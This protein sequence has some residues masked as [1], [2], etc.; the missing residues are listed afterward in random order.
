MIRKTLLLSTLLCA[1]FLLSQHANAG[2]GFDR[3]KAAGQGLST[4]KADPNG[5]GGATGESAGGASQ[6]EAAQHDDL[7]FLGVYETYVPTRRINA[8]ISIFAEP[9][10]FKF[11]HRACT[12][13]LKIRDKINTYLFQHPPTMDKRSNVETKGM[14][15]GI[16]QAIKDGLRTKLEYF[17]SI[18]VFSGEWNTYKAPTEIKELGMTDCA[19]MIERKAEMDKTK[20]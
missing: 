19:G 6:A 18:Y 20:K 12:K 9:R 4:D 15:E 17:T 2:A 1:T 13:M 3:L 11:G 7:I 16:R 8:A 10:D 5:E 14:D